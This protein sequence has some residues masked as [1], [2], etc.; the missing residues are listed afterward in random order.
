MPVSRTIRPSSAEGR[1]YPAEPAVLKR[2]VAELLDTAPQS[3]TA[4]VTALVAPHAGYVYSGSTAAAAF[5]QVAGQAF[6][7]V[8][9]VGPSH[10]DFFS[11]VTVYPG[12]AY[13]TPL[14]DI[15]IDRERCR[16]LLDATPDLIR[17]WEAGHR[18]EHGIEVELPFLQHALAPGWTLVPL[19][20][21][22]RTPTECARL[23]DAIVVASGNTPVLIVASSDLYHGYDYA[24]CHASDRRTLEGVVQLDPQAFS[25]G[26][27][28]GVF[29]ACGGGPIAVAQHL[30]RRMP[31]SQADILT[32][33]TSADITGRRDGYMVGYG[34]A[35]FYATPVPERKC[36][37]ST[38]LP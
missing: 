10:F 31:G 6:E 5:G 13:R 27:A 19:V 8:F 11:G 24:E 4:T 32:H 36:L 38:P 3:S 7:T 15:P 12:D 26:L 22:T 9:V 33:T 29:Q 1:F 2:Q 23:A 17:A 37:L 35:A 30:A 16:I 28:S 18:E 21:G 34:A 14:G 25:D 20:M